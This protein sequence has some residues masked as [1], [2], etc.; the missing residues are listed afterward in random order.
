MKIQAVADAMVCSKS[1]A[2][3]RFRFSH[4]SVRSATERRGRTDVTPSFPPAGIRAGLFL[5]CYPTLDR[6]GL[7]F[8]A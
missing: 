8:S 5:H 6:S 1:L 7:E 3:R 2:R 4:A